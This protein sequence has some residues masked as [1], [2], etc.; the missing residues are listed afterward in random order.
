MEM[1]EILR[2]GKVDFISFSYYMSNCISVDETL[3]KTSGNLFGGVK[4]PYLE[5]NDWGWQIDP[6]GLQFT[7]NALYGRYQRPLIIVENGLW[8][9]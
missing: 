5:A 2:K 7:L 4:N 6:Q 3:L 1:T 8:C 9:N